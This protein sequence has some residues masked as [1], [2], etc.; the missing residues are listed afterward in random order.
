M[1]SKLLELSKSNV[2][3]SYENENVKKEKDLT[4]SKSNS[5]QQQQQQQQQTI[6]IRVEN[7]LDSNSSN[8]NSPAN[9]KPYSPNT[10]TELYLYDH[11]IDQLIKDLEEN[12][13]PRQFMNLSL[14]NKE[15]IAGV[16][17]DSVASPS[18]NNNNNNNTDSKTTILDS[19]A[20]SK[21]SSYYNSSSVQASE[22]L[23]S[24]STRIQSSAYSQALSET[25]YQNSA[26]VHQYI[27][28]SSSQ[29]SNKHVEFNLNNNTVR[30]LSKQPS[31]DSDSEADQKKYVS[32][33]IP[34]SN[35]SNTNEMLII[36][37]DPVDKNPNKYVDTIQ[38]GV[39]KTPE[40]EFNP[41]LNHSD[42]TS[43]TNTTPTTTNINNILRPLAIH[44]PE[45]TI[46][47]EN[48]GLGAIKI[49]LFYDDLRS[50][51]SVTIHQAQNLKNLD[52]SKKSV[53]D[54]YCRVYLLPDDKNKTL[55]RKTRVVKV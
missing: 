24:S 9:N 27:D 29:N 5:Q 20:Q 4:S 14:L 10:M 54:P 1:G 34:D 51:L 48:C 45:N 47:G 55:K 31:I 37:S 35:T 42:S 38:S 19:N 13:Q 7:D 36:K 23:H 18:N 22:S 21:T 28:Q 3:L 41:V 12:K 50:R 17:V 2:D 40:N 49:T 16:L 26:S 44:D 6:I 25:K 43:N 33:L 53:S 15:N 32:I 52:K 8:S 30:Q 11:E 46:L 39:V